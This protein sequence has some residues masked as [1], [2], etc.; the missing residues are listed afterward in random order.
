M[1]RLQGDAKTQEQAHLTCDQLLGEAEIV[2]ARIASLG[3]GAASAGAGAASAGAGAG[4][5][6]E[7]GRGAKNWCKVNLSKPAAVPST[8]IS[9]LVASAL[10]SGGAAGATGK[11]G[12]KGGSA[13]GAR[14]AS[15]AAAAAGAG[16]GTKEVA[17][18]E[19]E[20]KIA[21][22]MCEGVPDVNWGDIKGLDLAMKTVQ[23]TVILPSLRPDVFRGLL[24]PTKGTVAS[25][26][27]SYPFVEL[28]A[29]PS[30]L[31]LI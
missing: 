18:N 29:Q 19:F 2:K 13:G 20:K 1:S 9:R 16:V 4:G 25:V 11:G 22:D 21:D 6:K 12:S 24:A 27:L 8:D 17:L 3:A 26:A 10:G 30:S 31:K 5:G 15:P 28:C 7:H 23:E 14:V